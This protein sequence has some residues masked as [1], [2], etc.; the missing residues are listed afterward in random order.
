MQISVKLSHDCQYQLTIF[1]KVL[2]IFCWGLIHSPDKY[3]AGVKIIYETSRWKRFIKA[4]TEEEVRQANVMLLHYCPAASVQC[5][6]LHISPWNSSLVLRMWKS[7]PQANPLISILC[8][9]L[10][11]GLRVACFW[12]CDFPYLGCLRTHPAMSS[13]RISSGVLLNMLD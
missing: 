4:R 3:T 6:P 5:I 10:F 2:H 7:A 9:H 12:V 8:H 13:F 1:S 11:H